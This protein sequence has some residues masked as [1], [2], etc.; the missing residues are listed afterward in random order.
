MQKCS[1][2]IAETKLI[3]ENVGKKG[4]LRQMSMKKMKQAWEVVY[5]VWQNNE[6]GHNSRGVHFLT[7]VEESFVEASRIADQLCQEDCQNNCQ[8]DSLMEG[9]KFHEVLRISKEGHYVELIKVPKELPDDVELVGPDHETVLKNLVKQQFVH[10]ETSP[11]DGKKFYWLSN[12]QADKEFETEQEAIDRSLEIVKEKTS[13]VDH[14]D[15]S[16]S[17]ITTPNKEPYG[18]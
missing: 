18:A 15:D 8:K 11:M 17:T 3:S 10:E 13:Q 9:W 2:K 7:D 12:D 6:E 16:A 1:K 5:S 14:V 4:V